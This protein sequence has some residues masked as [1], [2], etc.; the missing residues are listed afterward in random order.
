[1]S[2]QIFKIMLTFFSKNR[3]IQLL[4]LVFSW[5]GVSVSNDFAW[6]KAPE[7]NQFF[8]YDV[9]VQGVVV[10]FKSISVVFL[11]CVSTLF[12]TE[13]EKGVWCLFILVIDTFN[14]IL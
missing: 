9:D 5:K 10:L 1:M 4:I 6:Q 2:C 8:P 11:K 14:A 12:K 7:M 13:N 3:Y